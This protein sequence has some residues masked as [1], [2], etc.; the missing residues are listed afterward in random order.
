MTT[1]VL[2]Q[3]Q[4][5]PHYRVPLFNMLSRKVDLTVLHSSAPPSIPTHFKQI[6]RPLHQVGPFLHQNFFDILPGFDV[7][8]TEANLRFIISNIFNAF[9]PRQYKWIPWGIGVSASY[10]RSFARK[11]PFE[12]IRFASFRNANA[13]I[14]YSNAV[15]DLYL[16]RGYASSSLFVANNTVSVLPGSMSSD[17]KNAF[18]FVGSMHPSK[19][20]LD[21]LYSYNMYVK[22]VTSPLS[23]HIVGSGDE[24][25]KAVAF[26]RKENLDSLVVFHGSVFDENLLQSLFNK[27]LF[28]TSPFQAGL[29]VLKSFGYSTPFLTCA[30]A[31]TGGE[32][33]NIVNGCNGYLLDTS[34]SIESFFL[35]AHTNPAKYVAMGINARSTYEECASPE[36]F[37]SSFVAAIEYALM[38]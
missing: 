30:N 5:L 20:I 27:A 26:V 37:V 25:S 31:I 28:C 13:L 22:S 23:F 10:H 17:T 36:L 4:Q 15:T 32:R 16:D 2:I 21:L 33:F 1:K 35:D 7:V 19:R 12:F 24:Y 3:Q 6:T 8:I 29:S 14:F 34:D 9:V 11:R 38:N 18:L